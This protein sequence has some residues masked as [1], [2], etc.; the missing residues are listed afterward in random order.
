MTHRVQFAAV[1]W[2]TDHVRGLLD[3]A[4]TNIEVDTNAVSRALK[5]LMDLASAGPGAWR[6]TNLIELLT[7]PEQRAML[8]EVRALMSVIEGHASWVMNGAGV[9]VVPELERMRDAAAHR[10]EA[11]TGSAL[12]RALGIAWKLQQYADGERFFDAVVAE[13]GREGANLVWR[14]PEDLPTF[15]ELSD[16][17]AWLARVGG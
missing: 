11:A 15:D 7:T 4:V 10:R 3:R 13:A 9:G 2:L 16:A 1:P 6:E 8:T 14:S 5:R 12:P 17:P